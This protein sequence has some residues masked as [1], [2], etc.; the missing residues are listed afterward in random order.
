MANRI[1]AAKDFMNGTGRRPKLQID[2]VGLVYRMP[3]NKELEALKDV[4]FCVQEGEFVV[5][6][7]TSGCGKSS[8][9]RL[10]AGLNEP[11]R[12]S[13]VLD[14]KPI[15]T[16]GADRGMVFQSYTLFPWLTVRRN[17]SFGSRFDG[18][19]AAERERVVGHFIGMVGLA[20]FEENFPKSL[21]GGMRQRVALARTLAND[22]EIILMDE[23]FGA[24]DAQTRIEMQKLLVHI[25][26]ESHKTIL[27]V[28]HDIDEA[29][30]L[31]D[32]V[33]V[34]TNRPGQI[35][36]D[37]PIDLPRPR[38]REVYSEPKFIEA[39]KQISAL[40]EEECQS[41]IRAFVPKGRNP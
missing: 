2:R 34:M 16:F 13:I 30:F 35:K 36:R 1:D 19:P 41:A 17:V 11:T 40:I 28:T 9:L 37:F 38:P 12:G 7:G 20:G 24:L 21:S 8:L 6:V 22:P 33:L 31:G 5:I 27:F 23:P 18:M 39:K 10:I 26:D 29:I 32:R 25:W 3:H 15:T 14:G 4:S